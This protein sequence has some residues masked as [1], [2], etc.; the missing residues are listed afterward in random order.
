MAGARADGA[1]VM[2]RRE[3][4]EDI[5]A[6]RAVTTAA[7]R[8]AARSAPPVEPGGDPGETTLVSWLREDAGWIPALSLVAIEDGQVV[9]HVV[10]TR[11]HV[12]DWPALGVGPLSVL[13]QRQRAGI[14]AALLHAVLGAA[15]ALDEPLVGLL[16]EPA[17]YRRFG[18]VPARSIGI[19]APDAS[20]GDDFQVR[21]LIGYDG[22]SGRFAFAEPF[23]RL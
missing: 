3:L 8:S 15:E 4:P 23:G 19:T 13:P 22:R 14:G 16:G 2:I 18:F 9:G 12:D 20:W 1:T 21:T 11:A 6:I 17:Y 10:A 7:F 5:A